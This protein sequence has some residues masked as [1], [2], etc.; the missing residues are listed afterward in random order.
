MVHV[1][2]APPDERG[3]TDKQNLTLP[4]HISTLPPADSKFYRKFFLA[5]AKLRFRS[6]ACSKVSPGLAISDNDVPVSPRSPGI[7]KRIRGNEGLNSSDYIS[8]IGP[9]AINTDLETLERKR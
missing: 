3:G 7:A 2:R 8:L 9:T 4:R 5:S 1:N 6:K